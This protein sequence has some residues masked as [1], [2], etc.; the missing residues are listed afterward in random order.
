MLYK[1][2][3]YIVQGMI[4]MQLHLFG[5]FGTE[6]L[7]I[8]GRRPSFHTMMGEQ[9]E[10]YLPLNYV[11]KC[12][13]LITD[14]SKRFPWNTEFGM[15]CVCMAKM[16]TIT[17]PVSFRLTG[18]CAER[19]TTSAGRSLPVNRLESRGK[20]E[21]FSRACQHEIQVVPCWWPL[22]SSQLLKHKRTIGF[23]LGPM[24]QATWWALFFSIEMEGATLTSMASKEP[25]S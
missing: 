9:C 13:L 15:T 20:I 22:K 23:S 11:S 1:L 24:V 25:F 21:I 10:K 8:Q 16:T 3:Y 5:S 17:S 14:H 4:K 19:F 18:L 12:H 7:D 6:T 2:L